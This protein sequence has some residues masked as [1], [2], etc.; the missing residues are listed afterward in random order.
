MKTLHTWLRETPGRTALLATHLGLS[1]PFVTQMATGA[2]A[3]PVA[4]GAAIEHFTGGA[5]TRQDMFPDTW[6]RYWPELVCANCEQK[7]APALDQQAFA[8]INKQAS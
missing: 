1:Q 5:V 2:K 8:A 4:H 7:H 6:P 3:I